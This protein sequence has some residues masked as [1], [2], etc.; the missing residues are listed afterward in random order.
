MRRREGKK[1][2]EQKKERGGREGGEGRELNDLAERCLV[3]GQF[4]I[5]N[6]LFSATVE[7]KSHNYT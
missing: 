4:A 5:C 3:M 1:E 6:C 2:G 7:V